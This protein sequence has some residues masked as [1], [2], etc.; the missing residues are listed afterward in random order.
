MTDMDNGSASTP[1]SNVGQTGS[2]A[3]APAPSS[4]PAPQSRTFTQSEV[5]D[6]VGRVRSETREREHNKYAQSQANYTPQQPTSQAPGYSPDDIQ[7]M[8]A[9]AAEN[10]HNQWLEETQKYAQQQEAEKIAQNFY[11]KLQTGKEKYS[12]FDQK[13][14]GMNFGAMPSTVQLAANMENTADIMYEL[15]EHPEKIANIEQLAQINPSLAV[16]A[17]QQLSE[18]IKTNQEAKQY[19]QPNE[20]LSQMKPSNQGMDNKGALTVADYKR[21]YRV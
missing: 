18:S 16:K 2:V 8:V 13:L 10:K 17:M 9:E 20:P 6:I 1:E 5:D 3:S 11:Q 19:Q 4:T 14:Q 21:K 7:K 15:N 12:D